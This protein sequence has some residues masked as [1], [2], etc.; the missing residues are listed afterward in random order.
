[1]GKRSHKRSAGQ[2]ESNVGCVWGLMRLLY[3]RRDPRLLMDAKQATGRRTLMEIADRGHST[4]KSRDLEEM[5]EDDN[6][7]EGTLQKPTVKKLMDDELG[8]VNIL[9]NI[10]NTE[11]Q[12]RLA[13]LGN[14]LY[15]SGN[16]EH[17]NK[18]TGALNHGTD[19]CTSY[20]S[21]SV[22][23]EGSKS[24]NHAEAYDLESVLASFLGEIYRRHND[25]P[26]GDCKS[27]SELCPA[28][29]SL[30]HKKLNDLG[31]PRCSLDSE[32][33]QDSK[34][35][36]LLDEISIS[37]SRAVQSKEFKDAL[38]ILGSNK[39]LFLKLLQKPNSHML[40]NIRSHQNSRLT[41][42]LEPNKILGE[43]N[44]FQQ[45]R[46]SND[47]ELTAKAQDRESKHMFFW[48]KDK[49][50]R[51]QMMPEETN[52][53]EPVSK[54][55]ILKP[56]PGRGTDQTVTTGVRSLHQQPSALQAPEYSGRESSKFS[57]KEVRRRFRIVT[58]ETR[59]RN[60]APADGLQRV[61]RWQS[62]IPTKKDSGHQTQGSLAD[63][64][65]SRFK[66][67][68]IRP[69]T[70]SKQ[71]QQN[72]GQTKIRSHLVASKGTSIFYEEAKK[73]LTD[74]LKDNNQ[75]GDYPTAQVSKSLEGML[76]LPHC[77]ASYPRSIARG[78]CHTDL[79]PEETDACLVPVV[80]KEESSEA[81]SKSW[82]LSGKSHACCTVVAVDNQV[83]VMDKC[84]MKE[85]SQEG[86]RDITDVV[87]T[88][89]IEGIDEMDRSETT[90]NVQCSP[91]EQCRDSMQPVMLEEAEQGKEPDQM[92][93]SYPVS[94]VENLDQQEPETPE[95]RA[96]V[97]FITDCLP[98][99]NHEKQE[100]PSPVSVLDSFYEDIADPECENMKQCDLHED[101][102]ATLYFPDSESDLK[103]FWEDKN[104][105]LEIIKLVLELSELCAEQNLEVWYLE[106]ELISP[107]L[108]EELPNQGDQIDDLK[109]L[110]D[111]ICE[112]LP[113][114]QERYFRVSSWLS[115]LKH[116][117]RTPPIGENLISEVDKC[118]DDYLHH[119]FP[120]TLDHTI[121]RD[122]EVRTWMD[123]RS[124]TEGIVVEIWEYV[125]EEL[126]DEAVFDL[127]I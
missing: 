35:E 1:M 50:K 116:D 33:P 99:Q 36:M 72:G 88:I 57:I 110:F 51:K 5:D 121:K 41:T 62:L 52:R 87:D 111:C 23:S 28:L 32:Q 119:S 98:E 42:K 81:R 8:R 82:D 47:H 69:S 7:K 118:V 40:D 86:P 104:V 13:D 6:I 55:V 38:E 114:I 84:S 115:F 120:N 83:V 85:E 74:M 108:F 17:T 105:R 73:H 61:P 39:E 79:S 11:V 68:I 71:M 4:K 20:L 14:D 9:K 43:T 127:W 90:C 100:Q 34:G 64:S 46:C 70:S 122:L 77:D 80:D 113:E 56:N 106:D 89:S 45:T 15:L 117:I 54:I 53:S 65:A 112:A 63:K 125:L 66:N 93:L 75:S 25:C 124:K 16:S 3:F 44:F 95:P 107:C 101:L 37:S 30:I 2:D 78:K 126:L 19:I 26:H 10:P 96:S 18:I 12:G 91:V 48:R 109:L 67:D 24:L 49:S 60:A 21:G 102:R 92:L 97:K 94:I 22:D 59:E 29:K 31:S 76:S 58:G 123:I 103:V 27:N